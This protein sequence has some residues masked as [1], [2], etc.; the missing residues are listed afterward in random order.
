MDVILYIMRYYELISAFGI[1]DLHVHS[2]VRS[3]QAFEVCVSIRK[4]QHSCNVCP[5]FAA[6]P[7]G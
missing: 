7:Q 4:E 1:P 5:Q 3:L 2:C 6:G